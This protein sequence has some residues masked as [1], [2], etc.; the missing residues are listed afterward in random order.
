[1]IKQNITFL[2]TQKFIRT[3]PSILFF[4]HNNLS[5]SQ[6]FRLRTQL[7]T[8][9]NVH[10]LLLKNTLITNVLAQENVSNP[11]L[12][13]GPCFALGTNS[14]SQFSDIVKITRQEP[15]IVLIGG[16]L[17][18][19]FLNHLDIAKIL[20]VDTRVHETFL[21]N[22]NQSIYLDT[23]LTDSLT[24]PVNQLDQVSWNL[25]QCLEVLKLKRQSD[26]YCLCINIRSQSNR[27]FPYGYL[28]TTSLQLSPTLWDF[29][30]D[31][32]GHIL[33]H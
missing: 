28:V 23:I 29:S 1:M 13:Q 14:P 20:E 32:L 33:V 7:K 11:S 8:M 16:L 30:L 22:L 31:N 26:S 21:S 4:Q 12:F 6:W 27:R 3:Y 25:L 18:N 17:D 9:E 19:Q 24:S 2:K 5:V 10:L 15:T